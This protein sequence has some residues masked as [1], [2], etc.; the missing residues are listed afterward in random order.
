MAWCSRV[1]RWLP[2]PTGPAGKSQPK[3]RRPSS[4]D[5]PREPSH[6]FVD[7]QPA[8][9]P[10]EL[11][12]KAAGLTAVCERDYES[13]RVVRFNA[14]VNPSDGSA[15]GNEDGSC[16]GPDLKGRHYDGREMRP[17]PRPALRVVSAAPPLRAGGTGGTT[18]ARRPCEVHWMGRSQGPRSCRAPRPSPRFRGWTSRWPCRLDSRL[19]IW[20]QALLL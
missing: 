3:K 5:C 9:G 10:S 7:G 17:W 11:D 2:S 1:P 18:S 15:F 13:C 19:H 12:C 14:C 16:V 4:P 8:G 6:V 20:R